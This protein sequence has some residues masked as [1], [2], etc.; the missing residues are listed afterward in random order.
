MIS[1]DRDEFWFVCVRFTE[2]YLDYIADSTN[3]A[4]PSLSSS[5]SRERERIVEEDE[6]AQF[7]L[8]G[9][10]RLENERRMRVFVTVLLSVVFKQMRE[11]E[12]GSIEL[13]KLTSEVF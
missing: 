10:F 9:P 6:I 8:I 11:T 13:A 2:K 1:F 3:I 7:Q 5:S 12:V 4:L